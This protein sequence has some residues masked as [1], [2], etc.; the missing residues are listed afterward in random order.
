MGTWTRKLVSSAGHCL[1]ARHRRRPTFL[2]LVLG[3]PHNGHCGR[4]F[5][6]IG[7]IQGGWL[8]ENLLGRMPAHLHDPLC[9][10]RHHSWLRVH[11]E[12]PAARTEIRLAAARECLWGGPRIRRARQSQTSC[13]VSTTRRT[14]AISSSKVR[15]LPSTVEENPHWPERHNCSRGTN[16]LASS[17]RRFS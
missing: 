9:P 8:F 1:R 11:A 10:S 7:V 2:F 6:H 15:L 3:R 17:I 13:A 4:S 12:H 16:L 14:L 5:T